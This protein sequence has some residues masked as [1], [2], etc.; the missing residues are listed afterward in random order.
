MFCNILCCWNMGEMKADSSEDTDLIFDEM[1][2]LSKELIRPRFP[3]GLNNRITTF[4]AVILMP[5]L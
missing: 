1:S 3:V 5:S 4:H 2:W